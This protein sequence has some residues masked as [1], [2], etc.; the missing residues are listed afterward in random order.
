MTCI[1]VQ[2][3][4]LDALVR[5]SSARQ[6]TKSVPLND[7]VNT[8]GKVIDE[9]TRKRKLSSSLDENNHFSEKVL[10]DG[11]TSSLNETSKR[12]KTDSGTI[13]ATDSAVVVGLVANGA[14]ASN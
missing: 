11:D 1:I 4:D 13:D 7:N 2:F 12:G 5:R 6:A 3:H 14:A 8:N 9:V 10:A